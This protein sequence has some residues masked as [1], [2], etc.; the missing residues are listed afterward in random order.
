MLC[1]AIASSTRI[2]LATEQYVVDQGY[3]TMSA[4]GQSEQI[5]RAHVVSC[6][7][8]ERVHY[9]LEIKWSIK[10]ESFSIPFI[11]I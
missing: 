7:F 4:L 9:Y 1:V 5:I 8:A 10:I 11:W 2:F 6:E 3:S